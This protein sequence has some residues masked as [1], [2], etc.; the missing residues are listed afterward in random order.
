MRAYLR[1][2]ETGGT[3]ASDATGNGWN[4]TLING[5]TWTGGKFA[6]AVSLDGAN[7]HVTLP[8]GVVNGLTDFTIATWVYLNSIS[9]WSRVFDFGT[10][11]NVNMFLTP[12]ISTTG[13]VRFAI[14]TGGAGGEQRISGTAALPT[15]VWTHV[16]VTRSGS[17]GIL[18]VNGAEVGRNS[19]MSLN[20]SSL[21]NTMNYIGRSQYSADPYLNGSVDDF[22]IYGNALSAADI[23]SLYAEEIPPGAPAAPT[24]LTAAGIAEGRIDLGWNPSALTTNYSVKRA[25]NSGGPPYCGVVRDELQR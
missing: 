20:P 24:G 10:G 17:T 2:D 7:D 25:T 18:Y 23:L 11:T 12:R 3:I 1:F 13:P 6:N 19:S 22:R 8:T 21:G 14:T 16:A 15:G 9:N 4:G 5:P